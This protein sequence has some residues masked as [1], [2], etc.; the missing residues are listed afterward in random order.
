[1]NPAEEKAKPARRYDVDWL[2]AVAMLATFLFHCARFFNY[3]D[4]HVKNN[5]LDLGMSVFVTFLSLWIMPIFFLLSG[6]GSVFAL[7]FR[8]SGRYI[9]ERFKR[10]IIPYLFGALVVIVPLQVYLER[11]QHSQFVGSFF[12]FY[13][14]YFDGLYGLG[15]NFGWLGLHL[16]FLEV[17]FLFSLISL[18]LFLALKKKA[19]QERI[20]SLA[21]W[22]NKKGGI[23]LFAVP[24]VAVELLVDLQPGGIGTRILGGW[25][26]VVYLFHFNCGY[27]LAC[28]HNF[29]EAAERHKGTALIAGMAAS[30]LLLT[31]FYYFALPGRQPMPHHLSYILLGVWRPLCSWLLMVGILGYGSRLLGFSNRA[32]RY[33]NEALLPFYIL[34]QTVI[35]SI[36]YCLAQWSVSV[37][38]K[39]LILSTSSFV[40]IISLYEVIRRVGLLRFLFGMSKKK[41]PAK[42]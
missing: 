28:D 6:Q 35:V 8:T 5:Q 10:L 42:K 40:I 7:G 23:F 31:L 17:L 21:V 39:Y 41:K 15:G 20:S 12:D 26:P 14:H 34:H 2:R 27:L 29:T 3:E 38:L 32:L 30:A 36:G 16:W 13:P 24:L 37:M 22:M 4:W 18:P 33:A 25:S 19:M 11:V 1:M 9:S